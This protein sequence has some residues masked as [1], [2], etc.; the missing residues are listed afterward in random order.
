M[1]FERCVVD[2]ASAVNTR[3]CVYCYSCGSYCFY[4]IFI[5]FIFFQTLL[6]P[7]A[8]VFASF[9]CLLFAFEFFFLFICVSLSFCAPK[10]CFFFNSSFCGLLLLLLLVLKLFNSN[11]KCN[12]KIVTSIDCK[13]SSNGFHF[14]IKFWCEHS[15]MMRSLLLVFRIRISGYFSFHGKRDEVESSIFFFMFFIV[16]MRFRMEYGQNIRNM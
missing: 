14:R 9:A 16:A 6:L 5:L 4:L 11:E 15:L 8:L 2:S 1:Q 7:I 13:A 10:A 12:E 3:I